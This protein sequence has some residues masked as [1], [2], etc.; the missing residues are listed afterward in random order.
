MPQAPNQE[1]ERNG[2]ERLLGEA[3]SLHMVGPSH[4]GWMCRL[5]PAGRDSVSGTVA[6]AGCKL[7]GGYRL[8]AGMLLESHG[9]GT[10][11][12][13]FPVVGSARGLYCIL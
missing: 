7:D 8:C 11:A 1:Q 10:H 6:V 12:V 3:W 4:L 5:F 9:T 13:L 2:S